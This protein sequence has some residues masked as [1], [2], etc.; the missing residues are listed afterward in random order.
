MKAKW[1]LYV[2]ATVLLMWVGHLIGTLV[3]PTPPPVIATDTANAAAY[4]AQLATVQRYAELATS[5][6]DGLRGMLDDAQARIRGLESR[7][8]RRVTVYDT[9]VSIV[10][11][12]VIQTVRVEGDRLYID[13]LVPDTAGLH[14]PQQLSGAQIGDC[15][16]GLVV[17]GSVVVCNR[18]RLG[19]V[20][21]YAAVQYPTLGE[22]G[23]KWERT[24][25]STFG[26]RLAFTSEGKFTAR[27][28][29]GLRL[30]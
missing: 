15:D 24:Y 1:V 4:R 18:P 8:P 16:D 9:L 21:L 22:L 29:K 28:E 7:P 10:R 3:R 23:L 12:T 6:R 26:V 19:H 2:V 13:R 20:E 25:R 11:D 5:Q 27:I 30:W 14:Q 17:T